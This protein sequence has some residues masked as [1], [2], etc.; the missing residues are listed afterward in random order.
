MACV[1]IEALQRPPHVRPLQPTEREP[2]TARVCYQRC[3]MMT[4]DAYDLVSG[5]EHFEERL[6]VALA[7]LTKKS[8]FKDE[9]S[10][11]E[12]A[13]ERVRKAREVVGDLPVRSL[14]LPEL[15]ALRDEHTRVLQNAAVDAVERLQAGITFHVGSRAPL[16]EALYARLKLP[17]LRRS[18]R[19]DFERFL[20]DFEK[21]LAS[22]YAKRMFAD[23]SFA[24]VGPVLEQ[25]KAAFEAWRGGFTMAPVTEA[26][27][28]D[29]RDELAH[30]AK[31]LELPLR[32]ARLLAEAALAPIKDAF[33]E[34][35][36]AARP[37]RR[38]PKVEER[39][40]DFP[41]DESPP[42]EPEVAP[43]DVAPEEAPAPE[44]IEHEVAEPAPK[45][46]RSR[47]R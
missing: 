16:L 15:E 33:E 12:L 11:L 5:A 42:G 17:A 35:G 2:R 13:V 46:K 23:A 6:E 9:K 8:G 36:L 22:G 39:P 38:A 1:T 41:E 44:V 26:E 18:D 20:A 27:A 30:A 43:A 37:R 3:R 10:W 14:R 40:I 28:N 24:F 47:A 19:E 45:A 25:V 31:R 21:R 7:E 4:V 32:Q 34:T 29:L